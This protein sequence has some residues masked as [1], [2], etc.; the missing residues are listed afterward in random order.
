MANLL[1]K[2]PFNIGFVSH[3]SI[4]H[5]RNDIHYVAVHFL[6]GSKYGIKECENA[7]VAV[8]FLNELHNQLRN[9]SATII[10]DECVLL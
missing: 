10:F 5:Y 2:T 1:V 8:D 6:D 4:Q 9:L 7:N 3:F